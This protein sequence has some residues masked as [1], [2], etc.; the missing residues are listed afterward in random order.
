[1]AVNHL[2]AGAEREVEKQEVRKSCGWQDDR[3]QAGL[4]DSKE[5]H[6]LCPQH[7][8]AVFVFVLL[9]QMNVVEIFIQYMP[10]KQYFIFSQQ[11]IMTGWT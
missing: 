11:D 3:M 4:A 10:F 1:M 8:F 9:Q 6:Y 7:S 2:R 5:I